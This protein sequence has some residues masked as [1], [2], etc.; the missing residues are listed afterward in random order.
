M[1]AIS[2]RDYV[3]GSTFDIPYGFDGEIVGQPESLGTE[4]LAVPFGLAR[5]AGTRP[6]A[7]LTARA[8]WNGP[9]TVQALSALDLR[10][11]REAP[12]IDTFALQVELLGADGLPLPTGEGLLVSDGDSNAEYP[13]G[14]FMK[15]H[16]ALFPAGVTA[17][18]VSARLFTY[19]AGDYPR[20]T[21]TIGRLWAGPA[22][23][24]PQ[25]IQTDWESSVVDPGR[26]IKTR[27]GQGWPE[28]RQ[29]SRRL[30]MRFSH[31]EFPQAFGTL[32][33]SDMDLQQLGYAIG[34]TE[35]CIVLPRTVKPDGS[36]NLQAMYR[37][38]LYAHALSELTIRHLGGDY[39]D[40]AVD[41]E[42][43]F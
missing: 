33:S 26:I 39:Y 4:Q 10:V 42:E 5:P 41:F 31:I 12:S 14:D 11:T 21:A 23:F 6:T 17:H 18:G 16:H 36:P 28:R 1:T 27:G 13:S 29:K 38:G 8:M 32:G 34:T 35:P 7:F 19:Y 25:G 40:A 24:P 43:L 2:Y 22:Y 9:R 30:S 37:L 20:L 3:R 15:H